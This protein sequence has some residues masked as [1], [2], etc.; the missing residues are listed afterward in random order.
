MEFCAPQPY[1]KA[2]NCSTLDITFKG[3]II[4]LVAMAHW[5]CYVTSLTTISL[6]PTDLYGLL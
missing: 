4:V 5:K 3:N 6:L 2:L 1:G